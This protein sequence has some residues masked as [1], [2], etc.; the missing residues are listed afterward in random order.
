MLKSFDFLL[1]YFLEGMVSFIYYYL[2][3]L[4]SRLSGFLALVECSKPLRSRLN[5]FS[6]YF[7]ICLGSITWDL[8]RIFSRS[9]VTLIAYYVSWSLLNLKSAT[10]SSSRFAQNT[11]GSKIG[12]QSGSPSNS[13][14]SNISFS[15]SI[16]GCIGHRSFSF[17]LY[18]C[19][20]IILDQNKFAYSF[21]EARD[22]PSPI[23]FPS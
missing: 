7:S 13:I 1:L 17:G 14:S 22:T 15:R 11:F 20:D 2:I 6:S 3:S 10:F 21:L 8:H 18:D 19:N 9:Y 4:S 12:F 23:D 5:G 16:S